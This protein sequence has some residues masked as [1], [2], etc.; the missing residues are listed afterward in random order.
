MHIKTSTY[1]AAGI[2]AIAGTPL[3]LHVMGGSG[4]HGTASNWIKALHGGAMGAHG[5]SGSPG[6]T[7]STGSAQASASDLTG[8]WT[9]TIESEQGNIE[10]RLALKQDGKKIS[11][12]MSNPH[13]GDDVPISGEY[14]D[15]AVTLTVDTKTDHGEM[16]LTLKGAL[17]KDDGSL[18][19]TMTS[20]MGESKW[21]GR[22]T[23]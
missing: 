21:V 23:Q 10:C 5:S 2:L 18:A 14:A 1:V 3:C 20:A 15:G 11:G 16:H 22:R 9:V 19:G 8:K 4:K 7:G 17:K 12:T 6:S 13:G